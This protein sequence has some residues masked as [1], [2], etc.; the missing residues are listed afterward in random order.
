MVISWFCG[1]SQDPYIQREL[2]PKK[3][4]SF[5]VRYSNSRESSYSLVVKV[6]TQ[7]APQ[8]MFTKYMIAKKTIR[9]H[10]LPHTTGFSLATTQETPIFS[11]LEDLLYY[12]FSHSIPNFDDVML[13]AT[14]LDFGQLTY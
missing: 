13:L 10:T 14:A 5:L 4:G 8:Q 7:G 11:S 9:D 6:A 2:A 12:Y 1:W 3:V